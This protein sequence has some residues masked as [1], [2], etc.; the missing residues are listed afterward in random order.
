MF[1]TLQLERL[2]TQLKPTL[3]Q[4]DEEI[5]SK[6]AALTSRRG[7]A[8]LLE[9]PYSVFVFYVLK[10]KNNN[11][12]QFLIP[13]KTGGSRIILAPCTALKIIQRKLAY[14]LNLTYSPR[15][16]A[17]GFVQARNVIMNAAQHTDKQ[18]LLNIDLQDFFPS[19]NFGR[20]RGVFLKP[21]Y[22]LPAE[23]ATALAQICC[24]DGKLPQGA[25]TSPIVSNMICRR[26]DGQLQAFASKRKCVYTR[27]ADDITISTN[28]KRLPRSIIKENLIDDETNL[29]LGED[30]LFIIKTDNKFEINY[31]KLRLKRNSQRQEVT[32]LIVNNERPNVRRTMLRQIR[33]MFHAWEKFG[34][35][36]AAVEHFAKYNRTRLATQKHS[37]ITKQCL[38]FKRI[39]SGK[40]M[41]VRQVRGNEYEPYQRF[42]KQF[43][44][45][46]PDYAVPALPN[47]RHQSV[48]PIAQAIKDFLWVICT[49][50]M[51]E[52]ATAFML[53]GI[54][55]VTN[56]HC[57]FD[58]CV[59]FRPHN[60]TEMGKPFKLRS[61]WID[62]DL[63]LA[64]L[65]FA[66]DDVAVQITKQGLKP[67]LG[68]LVTQ[69]DEIFVCGFPGFAIGDH[70]ALSHGHVMSR[71][72]RSGILRYIVSARIDSG[73]SGC[74]MING[75]LAVLGIAATGAQIHR[76][77]KST[78]D[79]VQNIENLFGSHSGLN[80]NPQEFE[81]I[82]RVTAAVIPKL[83][84]VLAKNFELKKTGE[85]P[86]QAYEHGVI[87]VDILFKHM[88][89]H[90]RPPYAKS[91]T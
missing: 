14:I 20:V 15:P 69:N 55:L 18:I 83:V 29:E 17:Y 38:I 9:I 90:L 65:S 28:Q 12:K 87:P 30:L 60:M 75:S 53:D 86:D 52:S 6:L 80:V 39:I 64:I 44:R 58:D 13:K 49:P 25:P 24:H 82:N 74:P 26:L 85:H 7:L 47:P 2:R 16:S 10:N 34:L 56:A 43:K 68:K 72:T 36:K 11:Y 70:P 57:V 50:D 73:M 23:V 8:D 41:F 66:D 21:P 51:T 35:E 63:D 89:A 62:K 37:T 4:S 79:I 59:A 32:G 84:D 88:P 91:F 5:R 67:R 3:S 71:K 46:D 33:A 78:S 1:P 27:Y 31:N 61:E 42:V 81:I 48:S 45:L 76:E 77:T 19:I 22:K 54:G 40:L